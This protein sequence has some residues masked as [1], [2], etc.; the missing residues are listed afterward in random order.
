MALLAQACGDNLSGELLTY[1]RGG[2][3]GAVVDVEGASLEFLAVDVEVASLEMDFRQRKE[4]R[5]STARA[6][7]GRHGPRS[8]ANGG[9]RPSGCCRGP[10]RC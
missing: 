9:R 5:G 8:R 1:L 2:A 6:Q 4:N 3:V 10:C 7:L